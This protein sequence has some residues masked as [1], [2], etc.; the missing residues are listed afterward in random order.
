[1]SFHTGIVLTGGNLQDENLKKK[2]N[3]F[4]DKYFDEFRAKAMQTQVGL[5]NFNL[6]KPN[7]FYFAVDRKKT[8]FIFSS[9]FAGGIKEI[10]YVDLRTQQGENFPIQEIALFFRSQKGFTSW[11]GFS[12][13]TALLDKSEDEVREDAAHLAA[14]SVKREFQELIKK[15]QPLFINRNQLEFFLDEASEDEFTQ[16]LLVPLL[17]H[18]GFATAQAK[19]HRDK[20]LE[21]GQDIQ[22]MKLQIPTGHWLYF[23]AQVK[24]GDINSNSGNIS[25][26]VNKVLLQTSAQLEW[27]MPDVEHN[28][29][30]KPDHILLIVSGCITE[31][32]KQFIFNHDLFKRKRVLL[33]ERDQIIKLCRENGLPEQVQNIILEFNKDFSKR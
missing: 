3:V 14:E 28:V 4:F 2:I 11:T 31:A 6:G 33:F 1:M 16:L 29:T 12:I 10:V 8:H 13:N 27:E 30:V 17:Q 19:G 18:I 24:K 22:R 25:D 21:F 5:P 7:N 23:S 15:F 20:T 32:A 26:N 9:D